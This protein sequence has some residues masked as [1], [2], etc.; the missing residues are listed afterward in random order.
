MAIGNEQD[1]KNIKNLS[2]SLINTIIQ[3]YKERD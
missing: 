1:L 2:I 3:K